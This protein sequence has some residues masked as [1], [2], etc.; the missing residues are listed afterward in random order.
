MDYKTLT[1][2]IL[3]TTT[4]HAS[5]LIPPTG[6]YSV[7]YKDYHFID[8]STCPDPNFNGKNTE[9]FSSDNSDH[10]REISTRIYYPTEKTNII[11]DDYYKPYIKN[12]QNE[13]RSFPNVTEE[14]LQQLENI[15]TYSHFDRPIYPNTTFPVIMFAPGLS[16]AAQEYENL[17]TNL[18]SNGYI[19]VGVNSTFINLTMLPNG[20]VVPPTK[21]IDLNEFQT[22]YI[23]LEEQDISYVYRV[24]QNDHTRNSVFSAMDIKRISGLGHSMGGRVMANL[25]HG[26]PN[27]FNAAASLDVMIDMK[28]ESG[29]AF[30]L[31]FMHAIAANRYYVPDHMKFELGRDGYLVGFAPDENNR[32]FSRHLNFSDLST[33]QYLSLYQKVLPV[34]KSKHINIIG[35]GDGILINH[36]TNLYTIAFF[37]MYLKGKQSDALSHCVALNENTYLKCGD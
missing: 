25:A 16:M 35:N 19:V 34:L 5:P 14:D 30:S 1:I 36:L 4:L 21:S 22:F 18:V 12:E 24:I 20:H 15:K 6:P 10:C 8:T 26:H 13:Y 28:R 32:D 23:P 27:M 31:P 17:I 33:L 2:A 29:K 3:L 9:D 7:G 11:G 37:D